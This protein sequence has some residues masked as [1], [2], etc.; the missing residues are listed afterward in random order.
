MTPIGRRLEL[1]A[2][3]DRVEGRKRFVSGRLRDGTATVADA[4]G[5]FV[6][7]FPGQP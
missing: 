2:T 1:D 6:E 4:E 5:L 7:L 3:L